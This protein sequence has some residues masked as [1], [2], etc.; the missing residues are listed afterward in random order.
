VPTTRRSATPRNEAAVTT[1]RPPDRATDRPAPATPGR[2]DPAVL[3][4]AVVLV[5]GALAPLL[6]S[7]IVNVALR[8]LGHDLGAP[9]AT[10]QWVTTGYLLA[11]SAAIPLTGWSVER[12]GARRM[13]L[14]A[15][16]LF[17]TGS[18]L[19][20]LANGPGTLIAFRV[21]QGVGGGLMLPV[22]QTLL[23]RAAGGRSL[24]RLM[25]VVTLPALAGPI[26]GPVVGGLIVGHASW[27][28]IFYVNVPLCLAAV[29]LA[30]RH[31]P[32]DPP[33][34]DRRLDLT[35]LL[36]L[37]PALTAVVYGLAQTDRPAG[38]AAPR[39]LVPVVAGVLL[40]AASVLR[41]VRIPEPLVDLRV[42]TSR[43]FSASTAL[44]FLS[45]LSMFGSM[46]LLPLYYQ[47][48]RGASVVAAGLLLAPQG[49]GSLLAR[50]AGGLTDRLG[51]RPVVLTGIALT[52]LGTLPFALPGQRP[53]AVL[54]ALALVV[55]GAGLSAANLAVMVGAYDGLPRPRIP[56]ASSVTRI[57][58]Q[59]GGSF[60][61]AVL[62]VILVRQL[63][64]H[65]P[66]TAYAH[67]FTWSLA[68]TA[69]AIVPAV[70]LPRRNRES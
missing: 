22:M 64:T 37:S 24:G 10:V 13:W 11:L 70:L 60:G 7:T 57:A 59:I 27:R 65:A 35:G 34:G 21:L 29:L 67:T 51:A 30:L 36:M 31:V 6:D 48:V 42:F 9:V 3:K 26:L 28:W 20:G 4:L 12:F 18:V 43:S 5:L 56:H 8:T 39:V 15:L 45:G 33:R 19:C 23:L 2:L 14:F 44:L 17:L 46:L 32:A 63:T 16:C 50:V 53:G 55:R 61:T 25:A 40:L 58:Q 47:Q 38:F 54:L 62:A 49:V 66:A 41:A 1:T 52:V 68:F 69:L